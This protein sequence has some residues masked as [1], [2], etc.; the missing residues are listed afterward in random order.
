MNL[1]INQYTNY[2]TWDMK[3]IF[4]EYPLYIRK[5][6][7]TVTL[8]FKDEDAIYDLIDVLTQTAN[9]IEDQKW[10]DSIDKYD[11]QKTKSNSTSER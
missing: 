6:N 8:F 9:E 1:H 10:L 3:K 2:Q 7:Y 11:N 4:D 5:N